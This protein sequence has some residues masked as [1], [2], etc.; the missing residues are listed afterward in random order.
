MAR[1]G[2]RVGDK[3]TKTEEFDERLDVAGFSK[4]ERNT[5]KLVSK[6]AGLAFVNKDTKFGEFTPI[7]PIEVE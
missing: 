1:P 6:E 7:N 2:E 4:E 5:I 3:M